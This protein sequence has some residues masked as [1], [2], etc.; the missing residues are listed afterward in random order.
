[1]AGIYVNH[2][3]IVFKGKISDYLTRLGVTEEM[4]IT[5][6]PDSTFT[7]QAIEGGHERL[8]AALTEARN[9]REAA[10]QEY[11]PSIPFMTIDGDEMENGERRALAFAAWIGVYTPPSRAKSARSV[12]S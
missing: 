10:I 12:I 4:I 11:L 5:F 7:F 8:E 1:M 2:G 9:I 3:K 6:N